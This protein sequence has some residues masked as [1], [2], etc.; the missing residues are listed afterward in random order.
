MTDLEDITKK[1]KFYGLYK[2][3]ERILQKAKLIEKEKF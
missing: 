2:R 3:L 1:K